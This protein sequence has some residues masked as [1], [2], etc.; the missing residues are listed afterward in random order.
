M[1]TES[2]SVTTNHTENQMPQVI[3]YV[4]AI[5]RQKKRDVLFVTFYPE[6][7][8][9]QRSRFATREEWQHLPARR[10]VIEWLDGHQISWQPCGG[11]AGSNMELAYQGQIYIDLRF[12]RALS[13]Y[14]QLENFLEHSDGTM[15]LPNTRFCFITHEF[16]LRNAPHDDPAYWTNLADR[17]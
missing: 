15:K 7:E 16:A 4:D 5:S 17:F 11:I 13:I 12:D 14:L 3:E 1:V 9:K 2:R 8:E 6:G 10:Q